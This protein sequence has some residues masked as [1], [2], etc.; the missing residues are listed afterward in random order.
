VST[1]PAVLAA[2]KGF[3]EQD[4]EALG[5]CDGAGVLVTAGVLDAADV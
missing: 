4:A 1:K 5:L 2:K 3:T